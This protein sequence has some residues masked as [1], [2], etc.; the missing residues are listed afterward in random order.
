MCIFKC[1]I[2]YLY[3]LFPE[4]WQ[5]IV[6]KIIKIVAIRF[7]VLRLNALNA[8]KYISAGA[9]PQSLDPAEA[10]YSSPPASSWNKANLLPR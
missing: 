6:R 2:V 9:L 5:L 8:P 3:E 10:A 1:Q 4:V 7:Q